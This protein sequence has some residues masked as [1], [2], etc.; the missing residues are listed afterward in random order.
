MV[1]SK[2]WH[3]R[4]PT[5]PGEQ[6][7]T[8]CFLLNQPSSYR[9]ITFNLPLHPSFSDLRISSSSHNS[10]LLPQPTP[11]AMAIF[12]SPLRCST[13]W[14]SH[15]NRSHFLLP[16][17]THAH[18]VHRVTLLI[19][20]TDGTRGLFNPS[21]ARSRVFLAQNSWLAMDTLKLPVPGS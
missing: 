17:A 21:T 3:Q 18:W 5:S 12:I 20:C 14:G 6:P 10:A 1:K 8:R 16:M 7:P 9:I 2:L 13:G 4:K 11:T 19:H 15:V